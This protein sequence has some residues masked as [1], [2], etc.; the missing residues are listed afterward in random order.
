MTQAEVSPA[1]AS[2][3]DTPS[4][5]MEKATVYFPLHLDERARSFR[6]A[7][8]NLVRGGGR[9]RRY[10][11]GLDKVS[12][13]AS[14]GERIGIIGRNGAGK[15]T[16]LR[17]LAGVYEPDMG[18]I[19]RTGRAISLINLNM[20]MDMYATGEENIYLRAALFNLDP[21]AVENLVADVKTF[22]ELGEFMKEP[23]RTYSSGML[24][25]LSFGIATAIPADI[26]LMDEWISA[27]D[28][29]FLERAENRMDTYLSG[30][31]IVFLASHSA[32]LIRK[33]CNRVLV[34][35]AGRIA[36]DTPDIEAA[37]ARMQEIMKTPDVDGR[38]S[39]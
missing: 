37:L 39:V 19:V 20:G 34:M 29:R 6:W 21:E 17:T 4:V 31:K 22:S 23:I 3:F 26:I 33:W 28:M 30:H 18:S 16:L 25:R 38:K 27:G 10:F 32:S 8:A 36:M 24:A 35:D 5:E 2:Y 7:L 14:A 1:P 15:T 9:N 12:L 13:S 11:P